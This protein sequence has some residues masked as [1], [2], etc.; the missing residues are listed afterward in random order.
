VAAADKTNNMS[1][2]A[3]SVC[4][5]SADANPKEIKGVQELSEMQER[6]KTWFSCLLLRLERMTE[7]TVARLLRRSLQSLTESLYR[8]G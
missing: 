5:T 4:E 1:E 3:K 2:P 7:T 6:R 8:I